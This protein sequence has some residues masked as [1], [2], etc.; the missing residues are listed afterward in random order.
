MYI[1][2]SQSVFHRNPQG[3]V[4]C[5]QE[6]ELKLYVKRNSFIIPKIHLDKR[7]NY[8]SCFFNEIPMHWI[9]LEKNYDLYAATF[10]LNEEGNY[11]YSFI[12]EENITDEN[13]NFNEQNK[14]AVSSQKY[15]LLIYNKDYMTPDWTY[16]GIIYHIFVDRFYK[17]SLY[18]QKCYKENRDVVIR[19]DWEGIPHYLPSE[20]GEIKNNDFFGG[21]LKGI[22]EKLPYLLALGVSIIYLSPIFEAYSNHKYDTGDYLSIDPMFGDENA[23]SNLCK[24]AKKYGIHII[25]DGVFNH[26]GADS[27]Y[28]NKYD[29]YNSIGAYQ[30]K[31]S[32]YYNF[33]TF[34][35]W[36]DAYKCWWGIPTLPATNKDCK[37][38][39]DF[40]TGKNGVLEYWQNKGVKGWRLDVADE[41]P[42]NFIELIRSSVKKH[43]SEA[44]IVGEVWE[45]AS[46]KFSY[47]VLKKYFLG[48]QL[49]SVTNYPLKNAIIE[50]VKTGDSS[51]LNYTL[52][53]II[54]KYPPQA[55]DSLMNILGTHDTERILTILGTAKTL[56][57][58]KERAEYKLN[59]E[60]KQNALPLLK[61]ASLL[62]F[63]LPGIPCI[64]YGDE[65]GLEG[66]E[67]PFNRR[68]YP[69]GSEN[70]EIL[71][72]YKMLS[73]LRKN[74]VFANGKYKCL[75]NDNGIFVFERYYDNERIII[76]TNLSKDNITLN[77]KQ[78]FKK[79]LTE[80]LSC[81]FSLGASEYLIIYNNINL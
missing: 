3:G 9:G 54:E 16:G 12:L 36:N 76:A 34:N 53:Y 30:S 25:L 33:Y 13:L 22:E 78:E 5:E 62:Q 77:L 59:K 19:N 68:C 7:I 46:N 75:I 23:L 29:N 73:K 79:Y 43:D 47:D 1:F 31:E 10:T 45:D 65:A 67:D 4:M 52:N 74:K 15:E 32:P 2:D 63:T 11:F 80:N 70:Y 21:N 41:L 27:I 71:N 20:D 40:I 50:Y 72:H 58:R 24:E 69:W 66:F 44:F 57:T 35:R 6:I 28:F 14:Q 81:T 60:E 17:S 64:Y 55:V 51:M 49:D 56:E 39:V 8:D 18:Q 26:T 48:N 38:Y 42:D 37:G 61:I